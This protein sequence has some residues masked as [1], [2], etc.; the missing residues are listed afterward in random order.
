DADG[1]LTAALVLARRRRLGPF[2]A[3][4]HPD[5]AGARRERGILARAGFP[6]G[7]ASRALGMARDEAESYANRLRQG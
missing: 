2:R 4:G 7:V 6:Q 1:E 5:E 3:G